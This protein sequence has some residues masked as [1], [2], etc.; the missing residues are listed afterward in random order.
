MAEEERP[1]K[2]PQG[3]SD[4]TEPN[5]L[6]EML[7]LIPRELASKILNKLG[8]FE[9]FPT[10]SLVCHFWWKLCIDP[11]MW[12]TIDLTSHPRVGH[13]KLEKFCLRAIQQSSGHLQDI[14]IKDIAT[15]DILKSIAD[16]G[17]H[18]RR[19]RLLRCWE[20]SDEQLDEVVKKLPRLE[21][22]EISVNIISKDTLEL[23][24]KC[25][26]HLKVL[27]FNMKEIKGEECDDEAFAIAKTMPQLRHLQ[28]LGNRL[29][30]KGLIAILDGCPRLESL[31]LR[32]CSNVNL[33]G[34]LRERC[35]KQIKNLRFPDDLSSEI[36]IYVEG[37]AVGYYE[38][39][40]GCDI[41]QANYEAELE[42]YQDAVWAQFDNDRD[43]EYE[44]FLDA[45]YLE[46][47]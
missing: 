10:A 5:K 18:L 25:C 9:I 7:Q 45:H 28:L 46:L 36:S 44:E 43:D 8:A 13:A 22:F 3:S 2:K 4:R 24:G 37:G 42:A 6:G 35:C 19:L 33:S 16:S 32:V 27:K 31:D 17:S 38:L 34:S 40:C 1:A 30:N 29:T 47:L 23:M 21:E 20:I 14:S 26:P 12:R 39:D 11:L 41:D 15:D